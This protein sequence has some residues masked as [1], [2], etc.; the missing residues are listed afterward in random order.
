MA[1]P[2]AH[3]EPP[4]RA[5]PPRVADP[6]A[7][8]EQPRTAPARRPHV[9]R[10]RPAWLLPT[11]LAI[12]VA[13]VVLAALVGDRA[14][15]QHPGK[16]S[17]QPRAANPEPSSTG[18]GEDAST[19]PPDSAPATT[20]APSGTTPASPSAPAS[21]APSKDPVKTV[22][23]FYTRAADDDFE[24]AWALGT[25]NLH[26]QFPGGLHTFEATLS[27]LERIEFP[28]IEA[29][30]ANTVEFTSIA[31]HT[32]RTDR[33]SGT[34]TLVHGLIDHLSVQCAPK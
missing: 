30:D 9:A 19:A 1:E 3:A 22:T 17:N 33:C 27:T 31:H 26:A 25:D 4:R 13:G 23:A 18:N 32:N 11:L 28:S 15:E 2:S 24:G 29:T 10:R 5:E 20:P 8:A 14:D 12:I 21:P 16:A 6:P 34:A 7:H